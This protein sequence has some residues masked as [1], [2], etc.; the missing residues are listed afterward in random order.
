MQEAK[1]TL[2]SADLH[3][4]QTATSVGTSAIDEP[5]GRWHD[6]T[7]KKRL[8]EQLKKQSWRQEALLKRRWYAIILQALETVLEVMLKATQSAR[9]ELDQHQNVISTHEQGHYNEADLA[10]CGATSTIDAQITRADGA[11]RTVV[12]ADVQASA[13]RNTCPPTL[14]Q[15]SGLADSER[16]RM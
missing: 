13:R 5:R 14:R 15:R 8:T 10:E 4:H 7:Q 9:S 1:L 12:S 16:A 3:L 2:H 11:G 6:Q